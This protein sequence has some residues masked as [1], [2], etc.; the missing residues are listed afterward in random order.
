L[1]VENLAII[2]NS[3]SWR[4][5]MTYE[6]K[7]IESRWLSLQNIANNLLHEFGPKFTS[8]PKGHIQ[9]D[10]AAAGSLSGLMIL[11]ETLPNLIDILKETKPGNVL[12][13]EVHE[14]Q[15]DIFRFLTGMLVGNGVKTKTD[16]NVIKNQKPYYECQEMTKKIS[17][18][19]YEYCSIEKIEHKYYKFAA[20]LAGFKLVMA[21]KS[22]KILDPLIG[23]NI[24][25]Y[26]VVAGSKTIP[27]SETLW[28]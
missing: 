19:F 10:I 11:Q 18:I 23:Q 26:Y 22:T 12:L 21:G 17:S 3:D 15:N 28:K 14:R 4:K 20:A 27:Y 16:M 7:E 13:A 1:G 24:L 5:K 8:T 9:T 6:A 25:F 2:Y